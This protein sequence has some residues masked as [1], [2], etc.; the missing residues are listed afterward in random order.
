M[1][2]KEVVFEDKDKRKATIFYIKG[3]TP[4]DFF[5]QAKQLE[6]ELK[7]NTNIDLKINYDI[8][9][10]DLKDINKIQPSRTHNMAGMQ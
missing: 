5:E 1:I 9:V 10:F 8:M 2:E 7:A 6:A 4:K 3:D